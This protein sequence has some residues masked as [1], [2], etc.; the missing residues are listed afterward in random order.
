MQY[1]PTTHLHARSWHTHTCTA[2]RTCTPARMHARPIVTAFYDSRD[3]CATVQ[4][5][6][7]WDGRGCVAIVTG[8]STGLGYESCRVLAS[9]G[10]HVVATVRTQVRSCACMEAC[11]PL[12]P[13]WKGMGACLGGRTGLLQPWPRP[14]HRCQARVLPRHPP[15]RCRRHA[16]CHAYSPT[17]R[18][19]G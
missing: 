14:P 3:A 11:V 7:S 8:A 9:R 16:C 13:C 19:P 15:P 10:C 5:A 1:C 18:S 12:V 17:P 2:A 6:S 4:V